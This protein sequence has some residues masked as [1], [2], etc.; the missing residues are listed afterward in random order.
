[1]KHHYDVPEEPYGKRYA[2]PNPDYFQL[3]DQGGGGLVG[4]IA[5]THNR[6]EHDAF[7]T[8]GLADRSARGTGTARR[9]PVPRGPTP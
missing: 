1:M 7:N 6:E 3:I 9:F 5:A 4:R 8:G 2:E